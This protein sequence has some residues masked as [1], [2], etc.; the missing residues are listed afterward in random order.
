MQSQRP[1]TLMPSASSSPV[2]AEGQLNNAKK[3]IEEGKKEDAKEIIEKVLATA[4]SAEA[5]YLRGTL[6][7]EDADKAQEALHAFEDAVLL[8]DKHHK[9]YVAMARL[10]GANL[11]IFEAIECYGIATD[12]C[13]ENTQY[14]RELM[15]V[16]RHFRVKKHNPVLQE[17]ILSFMQDQEMDCTDMGAIW[18][19]LLKLTPEFKPLYKATHQKTYPYFKKILL[20]AKDHSPLASTYFT[21]GL[22]NTLVYNLEMEAFLTGLRHVLLDC[23]EEKALNLDN[24]DLIKI[25]VSLSVYCYQTEFI[26]YESDEEKEKIDAFKNKIENG[27]TETINLYGLCALSCYRPLHTLKNSDELGTILTAHDETAI[28][29]RTHIDEHKNLEANKVNIKQLTSIDDDVSRKVQEQYEDFPYPRWGNYATSAFS[30]EIYDQT[31]EGY[32]KGKKAD[33]LVAGC[34]TGREAIELAA[35]FPDSHVTAVDLS[36]T[37]LSYA[38]IKAEKHKVKNITFAHGDILRLGKVGKKFDYIA[39]SGVLHHMKDPV[40]GWTV[41]NDLLKPGCAMRIALYSEMARRGIVKAHEIIKDKG[42]KDDADGIRAF[43]REVPVLMKKHDLG[44]ITRY[45]DFFTMSEC[46]DLL[47]HVQEHRFNLMQIKGILTKFKLD[48]AGFHLSPASIALYKK[49]FADDPEAINLE[50]WHKFEERHPD[51]FADM[52]LFWC[53]KQK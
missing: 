17:K 14:K 53:R 26:F 12:I 34:G 51:T 15:E 2:I 43:R 4:P 5:H 42:F 32:L 16:I 29:A 52:Y 31:V 18:H 49:E 23:A 40:A 27:S 39:S 30:R 6:L 10:F 7:A 13:P 25:A 24:N 38:K 28:I 1:S 9:A 47:F 21:E 45:R 41:L 11:H 35:V 44:L 37:S 3:L 22:K 46:R 8:D 33:I 19:N 48:F 20:K 50:T 36:L